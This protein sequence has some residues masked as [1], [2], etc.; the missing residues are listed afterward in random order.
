MLISN[1]TVAGR[2]LPGIDTPGVETRGS[3]TSPATGAFQILT[4]IGPQEPRV[5]FRKRRQGFKRPFIT[6]FRVGQRVDEQDA[7]AAQHAQSAALAAK[8]LAANGDSGGFGSG[9]QIIQSCVET[10]ARSRQVV[11]S[12]RSMNLDASIFKEAQ[13]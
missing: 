1:R 5:H 7:F 2:F 9:N 8:L 13:M 6:R 10:H 11:Y 4:H 3:L 12:P